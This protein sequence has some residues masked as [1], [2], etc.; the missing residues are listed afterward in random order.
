MHISSS[1]SWKCLPWPKREEKFCTLW[2]LGRN[3]EDKEISGTV[4]LINLYWR[5]NFSYIQSSLSLPIKFYLFWNS[6]DLYCKISMYLT[7]SY[8]SFLNTEIYCSTASIMYDQIST[9]VSKDKFR[10][11]LYSI[12]LRLI[13]KQDLAMGILL[14]NHLKIN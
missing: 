6:P 8:Q 14:K 7:G 4:K 1:I 12:K 3:F 9:H 11:C 13:K 5:F 10:W 2:P